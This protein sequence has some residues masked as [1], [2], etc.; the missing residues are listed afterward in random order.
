M[1]SDL[2]GCG[3]VTVS[4]AAHIL[5]DECSHELRDDQHCTYV[6]DLFMTENDP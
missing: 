3:E 6:L 4:C 1:A 5:G 2:N